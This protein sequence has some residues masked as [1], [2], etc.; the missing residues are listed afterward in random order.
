MFSD[1]RPFR[2]D[3][4]VPTCPARRC[5]GVFRLPPGP[6]YLPGTQ[7][8]VWQLLHVHPPA[9]ISAISCV[10]LASTLSYLLAH[11]PSFE[12]FNSVRI[13]PLHIEKVTSCR[14]PPGPPARSC[15]CL[16]LRSAVTYHP[17]SHPNWDRLD[18]SRQASTYSPVTIFCQIGPCLPPCRRH[19]SRR[20]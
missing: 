1:G 3:T 20:I 8:L 14:S 6:V 12:V 5:S 7:V 17:S 13:V 9:L 10:S 4:Q 16:P 11:I 15:G 2:R 18:H 19:S